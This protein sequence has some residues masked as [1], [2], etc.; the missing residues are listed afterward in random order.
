[1]RTELYQASSVCHG[2]LI[3]KSLPIFARQILSI[4]MMTNLVH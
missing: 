4:Q 1:M 2:K 3:G